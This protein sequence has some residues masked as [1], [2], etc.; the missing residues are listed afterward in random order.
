[1]GHYRFYSFPANILIHISIDVYMEITDVLFLAFVDLMYFP[2]LSVT[3]L[4]HCIIV[5]IG[6]VMH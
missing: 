4:T 3:I 6:L 5:M 1:V 2:S